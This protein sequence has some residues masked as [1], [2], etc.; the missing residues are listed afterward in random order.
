MEDS[1]YLIKRKEE[2]AKIIRQD[3]VS[4]GQAIDSDDESKIKAVHIQM[5]G[6]YTTYIP[7]FGKSMYWYNDDNGF[8]YEYMDK[9]SFLH[10]LCIMKGRLEGYISIFPAIESS[11]KE[12]GISVNVP[13][14]NTNKVGVNVSFKEVSQQIEKMPGLTEKEINEIKDKIAELEKI[15]NEEIPKKK[16]W[17]KI[18]PIVAFVLEKGAEVAIPILRLVLQMKLGLVAQ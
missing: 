7:K 5:D 13:V 10:N 12:Q 3:I 9:K 6:K 16:K 14:T 15:N 1:S 8:A 4:I 2:T 11:K 17:A 18:K